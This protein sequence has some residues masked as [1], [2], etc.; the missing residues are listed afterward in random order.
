VV[1]IILPALVGYIPD[2]MIRCVAALL[3]FAY[4]ARR[5]SHDTACLREMDLCLER[6][7]KYRATFVLA[8]IRADGFDLPRQHSLV[9]YTR[10][11][12]LYGSPNGLCSSITESKHI[13]AV[14]KPWRRSRRWQALLAMLLT[15]VRMSKISAARTEFGRKGMLTEALLDHAHREADAAFLRGEMLHDNPDAEMDLLDNWENDE[16]LWDGLDDVHGA[17]DG[18]ADAQP[19]AADDIADDASAT[20]NSTIVNLSKPGEFRH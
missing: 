10:S 16:V 11:I 5:S 6:F 4:L 20:V 14:K 17:D 8:G 7:H 9:H 3:D 1:Q 18:P 19:D 12:F 15:N 2:D 13:D